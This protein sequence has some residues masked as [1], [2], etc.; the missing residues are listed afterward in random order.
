VG[1]VVFTGEH[2]PGF[3]VIDV[4]TTGFSPQDER[5]VEVGVVLLDPSGRETGAFCTL[6][7]PGR[8]P[9]PSHIHGISAGMLAGAPTFAAI[10]PTLADRLSGRVVV[11]HNV[12]D[13]DLCFLRAECHR[14]GR[15]L[16]PGPVPSI[17]TLAVAQAHLG[18]QGRARL[19]DCCTHFGLWWADHHSA[20]GDARVTAALFRSMRAELGDATLGITGLLQL[21]GG[22]TWPGQSG[23][24]PVAQGRPGLSATSSSKVPPQSGPDSIG[25]STV[26]P[27]RGM[28]SRAWVA[29]ATSIPSSI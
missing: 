8:D 16:A 13:F 25:Q 17:D 22:S 12:D 24:P 14:A 19:V 2:G 27:A 7:D 20:L 26:P 10:H 4:E 5:I 28:P 11:G 21:A 23:V 6:V 29:A 18:L 1:T 3:A 15:D 9:G